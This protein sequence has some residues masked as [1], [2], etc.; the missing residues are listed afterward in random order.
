MSKKPISEQFE[1]NAYG[2][3]K[4]ADSSK[5]VQKNSGSQQSN[6]QVLADFI[7]AIYHLELAFIICGARDFIGKKLEI[8]NV[9]IALLE[10]D[11]GCFRLFDGN[12]TPQNITDSQLLPFKDTVLS[13]IIQGTEPVYRP[14]IRRKKHVYAADTLY[15]W[16]NVQS[17][18]IIPLLFDGKCLGTLNSASEKIDGIS[19][20]HRRLLALLAPQLAK[21][22]WN[23]RIF[24]ALRQ[25]EEHTR[26]VTHELIRAQE[27]ERQTVSRNLHDE[28]AQ[29]LSNL[30][31]A[32]ETLFDH[33]VD[34]SEVLKQRVSDLSAM[35]K[36]SIQ[37]VRDISYKLRPFS[38]DQFGLALTI[39]NY[40]EE[41][42]KQNLI[43]V[44]FT[45]AGMDDLKLDFDTKINLYRL[46]QEALNTIKKHATA[47]HVLIRLV[48][49]FPNIILRIENDSKTL[50][51]ANCFN[52]LN[53]QDIEFRSMEERANLLNGEMKIQS[54]LKGNIKI[55]IKIPLKK[56][57]FM[58]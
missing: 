51:N 19:L 34:V 24:G 52:V 5:P 37:R 1:Q 26:T 48:A 57:V 16:E 27:N 55:F 46:A 22:L 53:K 25:K 42:S 54:N 18:F 47:H 41:F 28:V 49:S 56:T 10:N 40:C 32:F 29:E 30:R 3:K 12:L 6:S 58:I 13:E 44:D 21:S 36:A 9:S 38:L 15:I 7:E 23:S 39:F 17:V 20:A 14:D 45:A 33:Q 4:G 8:P 35:L 11:L 2:F 43:P 50:E 31:I